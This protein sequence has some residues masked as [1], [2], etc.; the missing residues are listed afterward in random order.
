M[1]T[2]NLESP[3]CAIA[4]LRS[5]P[6]DHPGMTSGD[7]MKEV[8]TYTQIAENYYDNYLLSKMRKG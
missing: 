4:H 6:S 2:W 5:G 3:R 7:I 1:R 8:L